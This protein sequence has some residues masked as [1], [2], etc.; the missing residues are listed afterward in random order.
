MVT[1]WQTG[2]LDSEV[3]GLDGERSSKVAA[4][5][6]LVMARLETMWQICAYGVVSGE[7]VD[8]RAGRQ[9]S[10]R[11]DGPGWQSCGEV[12][13]EVADLGVEVVTRLQTRWKICVSK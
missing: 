10:R 13:E 5:D 4:L 1:T 9:A 8:R 3:A 11:C 7:V 12:V 6:G 2:G